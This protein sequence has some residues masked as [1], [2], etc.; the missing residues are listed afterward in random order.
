MTEEYIPFNSVG[1][2]GTFIAITEGLR[3]N[4]MYELI[5][6]HSKGTLK[7]VGKSFVDRFLSKHGNPQNEAGYD[8]E[9]MF[10][11][12]LSNVVRLTPEMRN[13]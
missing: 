4:K 13:L 1:A 9:A 5:D 3:K 11:D 2:S 10:N 8:S 7:D 12:E 6:Y